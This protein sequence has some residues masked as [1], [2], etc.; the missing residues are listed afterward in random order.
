MA[1]NK[2]DPRELL[3]GAPVFILGSLTSLG[4]VGPEVFMLDF[5]NVLLEAGNLRLTLGSIASIVAL[6]YIYFN[7]DVSFFEFNGEE[8]WL[9]FATATLVLAPPVFPGLADSLATMP[10]ALIAF[11]LQTGGFTIISIKN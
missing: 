5:S 10:I 3:L 6:G 11:F 4:I 7:R 8:M 9:V 1:K 2:L